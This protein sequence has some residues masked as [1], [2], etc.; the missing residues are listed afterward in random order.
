MSAFASPNA[1]APMSLSH[2]SFSGIFPSTPTVLGTLAA[3]YLTYAWVKK[4]NK[5]SLQVYSVAVFTTR[6]G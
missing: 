1:N 3:I 6:Q 2:S 5:G 4:Q